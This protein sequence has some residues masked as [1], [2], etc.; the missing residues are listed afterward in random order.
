M[1]LGDEHEVPDLRGG[2]GDGA[3]VDPAPSLLHYTRPLRYRRPQ[4][5]A[6]LRPGG[7]H[8]SL[9]VGRAEAHLNS[10]QKVLHQTWYDIPS[11][12]PYEGNRDGF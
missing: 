7:V 12:Q 10:G 5:G 4:A 8:L 11:Y 2:E 6:R 1:I 9:P 3:G